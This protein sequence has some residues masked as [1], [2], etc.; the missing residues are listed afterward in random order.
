MNAFGYLLFASG[1]FYFLAFF[2]I[3]YGVSLD[4]VLGTAAVGVGGLLM[5]PDVLFRHSLRRADRA[6]ARGETGSVQDLRDE[7]RRWEGSE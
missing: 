2:D 5:L 3:D 6:L 4:E 1:V 7:L